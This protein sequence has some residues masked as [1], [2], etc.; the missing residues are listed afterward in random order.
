M[1]RLV[2]TT[3]TKE[4][5]PVLISDFK[6]D[7]EFN[8]WVSSYSLT[9]EDNKG[10]ALIRYSLQRAL[11]IEYIETS[12]IKALEIRFPSTCLMLQF[13]QKDLDKM[14]DLKK[15]IEDKV[16]MEKNRK[17]HSNQILSAL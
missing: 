12:Q 16:D 10:D 15:S 1:K 3:T 9:V 5:N 11:D 2:I 17:E 14:L 13:K 8:F 6:Y 7:E 4:A